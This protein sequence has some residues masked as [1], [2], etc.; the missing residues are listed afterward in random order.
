MN[1]EYIVDL[2]KKSQVQRLEHIQNLENA[3]E[4]IKNN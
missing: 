2:H 1:D 4:K 3:I